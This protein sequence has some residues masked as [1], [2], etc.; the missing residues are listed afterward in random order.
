[1]SRTLYVGTRK[2]LFTLKSSD[3]RDWSLGEPAYL[4]HIINHAVLDPR[5]QRTVV[6]AARTG[7]L[8]PTVLRST[9]AG[10]TW[11]EATRPPAFPRKEDGTGKTL[12]HVFWI[13]PGHPSHPHSWYAG[14]SPHGLFRSEDD[15]DTWEPVSGFNDHRNF[16]AWSGDEQAT[17]PGGK[18]THSVIVD[19]RDA[20]HLYLGLSVGGMF[21][22]LDEGASWRP[23]NKGVLADY[24]PDK[25]PEFGQ[26]AHCTRL[27]PAMPDRLYQQNHCGIYRVDRPS[28]EWIRIGSNMPAGV[29]DIG[30]PMAVHPRNPD[31]AWV[32][33][34][35]GTD[36]WPRTSPGGVPAVYVTRDAGASW[37]RQS[38]GLPERG[39]L[40]M[41]RQALTTDSDDPL[42]VY[43]G[44]TSGEVWIGEHEG[45]NWRNIGRHLPE[46]LSIEYGE[47]A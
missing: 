14:A 31:V 18:S 28:D 46:V 11:R 41:R 2:G 1:M 32:F 37:Q 15:G 40:T 4:G 20:R 9:D 10:A 38:N 29:G 33:P 17:P 7:H 44:T 5:D 36:V 47:P 45:S 27:H 13:T 43:F 25:Y 23:L 22:S 35:D 42:G 16:A 30:F 24:H 12:S 3:R 26:D 6:V 21:E 39:W 34:M 19:P 8:G